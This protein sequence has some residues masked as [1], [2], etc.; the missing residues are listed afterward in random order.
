MYYLLSVKNIYL[1]AKEL[2]LVNVDALSTV[3]KK[4]HLPAQELVL[5]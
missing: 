1:P 4:K 5:V 2:V 3:S